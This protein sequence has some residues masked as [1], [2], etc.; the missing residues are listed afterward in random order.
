MYLQCLCLIVVHCNSSHT[1]CTVH[2]TK[3]KFLRLA[4]PSKNTMHSN[5]ACSIQLR[6]SNN[7]SFNKYYSC[8]MHRHYSCWPKH[9]NDK[10]M[11]QLH[12]TPHE[13]HKDL[14]AVTSTNSGC[15]HCVYLNICR[16]PFKNPS[17]APWI[18]AHC[19]GYGIFINMKKSQNHKLF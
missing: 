12:T 10:P 17:K 4:G 16:L 8:H 3:G 13:M 1:L 19:K 18:M 6:Q 11:K 15:M 14:I 2:P 5:T 9:R 7:H